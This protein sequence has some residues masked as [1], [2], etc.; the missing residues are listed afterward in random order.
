M[1]IKLLIFSLLLFIVSSEYYL[2]TKYSYMEKI[3]FPQKTKLVTMLS[4]DAT[5]LFVGFGGS[6]YN[7][8]A[9]KIQKQS[10]E[11][12]AKGRKGY[13]ASFGFFLNLSDASGDVSTITSSR[14][15]HVI[16][17]GSAD[18]IYRIYT[19]IVNSGSATIVLHQDLK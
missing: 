5:L 18:H 17:V 15:L 2:P 13:Y 14:S 8:S 7:V 6:S 3:T 1:K 19:P 12:S 4:Y 16:G 11:E 10:P 9:Y